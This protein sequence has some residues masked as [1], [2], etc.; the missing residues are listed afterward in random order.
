[1]AKYEVQVDGY[2]GG[3]QVHKGDV[4]EYEGSDH[5]SPNQHLRLVVPEKTAKA[6]P[7]KTVKVL[8][9][10]PLDSDPDPVDAGDGDGVSGD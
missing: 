10:D 3:V 9:N 5:G 4:I 1:M 7:A 8:D 6:K 2:I